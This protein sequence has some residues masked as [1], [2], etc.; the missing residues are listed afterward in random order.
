[1]E[2]LKFKLFKGYLIEDSLIYRDQEAINKLEHY[3]QSNSV[4]SLFTYL[5]GSFRYV[6]EVEKLIYFGIDHFGGYPLFYSLNPDLE[7]ITNPREFASL[8]DI[9]DNHLCSL[10]ASGFSY[11]ETTIYNKMKECLPGI[12]YI[13]HKID[14]TLN[15]QEWFSIDY[16]NHKKQSK[17]EF[18]QLLKSL[19]PTNFT[20]THLALTGGIDSRH[21]LALFK[22]RGTA[23]NAFTYGTPENN[24]IRIAKEVASQAQIAYTQ[25][26]FAHLNMKEYFSGSALDE[27]FTAGFLGRSLP[28]ESDWVVSNLIKNNASWV[29][30]GY[31]SFWLRSPN[32]DKLPLQNKTELM[33]KIVSTHCQQTLISSG[34][35]KDV[36][37]A[38]IDESMTHFA[39]ELYDSDYDR[40]NVENRQ[41]KYIINSCNNYRHSEIEVFLPLFDRRFVSFLNETKREQ[42]YD[43]KLYM[44][45]ILSHIFIDNEEYL[46]NI[47]STNPK[48]NSYFQEAKQPLHNWKN[49]FLKLDKHNLNRVVRSPNNHLYGILQAVLL[50]SPGFL[51]LKIE[52][53]FPNLKSTIATLRDLGLNNSANHLS[54]LRKKRVVQ[55]NL[56]GIEIIGFLVENFA[57]INN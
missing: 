47:P 43:Q 51:S 17:E 44:E 53:A 32:Q 7:I 42:R 3:L 26:N 10:L 38:N 39:Q 9:N 55:L 6:I 2:T 23:I 36:L 54:W 48:Y 15:R 18:A 8:S 56:L 19:I 28:F 4:E 21:L 45:T 49:R 13:Y 11:G 31:T 40:W 27:F 46:K 20:Q 16:R 5:N 12:T 1:M 52:D 33:H 14:N 37:I 24:D 29:T 30:T 50:Q 35:F 22:K 34:K 25:Y 57:L 41:H